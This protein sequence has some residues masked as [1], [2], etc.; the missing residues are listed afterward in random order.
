MKPL[1][2]LALLT[3]LAGCATTIQNAPRNKPMGAVSNIAQRDALGTVD[4]VEEAALALSFSGGG[5]RASAFSLGVLQGL[6]DL[7]GRPGKTLLDDVTFITS[8]SGGSM[9]AAYYGLHG[10]DTLTTFR[11]RGLLRDSEA[12]LRFSLLNPVNVTRLLA[13]GLNDRENFQDW[14][15]RDLYKGATFADLHRRRKPDVWI[16]A[17][18]MYHRMAFP[19]IA[20]VFDMLCSDL[21][22]FPISEAV[23]ASMAVPLFFAPVVLEKHPESCITPLPPRIL[24]PPRDVP[25]AYLMRDISTAVRDF[26]DL[27]NGRYVK[28]IDGGLT[29]NFGLVSVLQSRLVAGT[30]YGPMTERDAV[31]VRRMMFMV[32]DAGQAPGG[33][34]NH[35]V[36]GPSGVDVANAAIDTAIASN[37]RMSFDAFV[38]MVKAWRDDIVRFRCALPRER[39][40]ELRGT[41]DGFT[42]TDVEFT[43]TRISFEDLDPERA[44]RLSQVPT[45]LTLP[46]ATIDELISAGRDAVRNDTLLR[47]FSVRLRP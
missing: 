23:A 13:G 44:R 45:R 7:Q 12:D 32:V 27:R 17:S 2:L 11:D 41:A 34:W 15:E 28:L 14:L 10:K 29:D 35:T 39:L 22:S 21:M 31:T 5:L 19:F 25:S 30:P 40:I 16:N 4:V 6:E 20:R 3:C 1:L 43:V 42:C 33:D 37:V 18:H 46:E 26:R 36:E 9:T 8:V 38:P 47:A 24:M